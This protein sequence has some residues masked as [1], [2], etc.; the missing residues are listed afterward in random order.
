MTDKFIRKY[1]RFA[2]LVGSD[3]NPCLSRGIGSVIVDPIRNKIVS[4]GYNGPAR[5]IP[6]M[7]SY[8]ALKEFIYPQ[9]TDQDASYITCLNGSK[10]LLLGDA[11]NFA[12]MFEGC[13]KCPRKLVGAK[14]GERLD[15]CAC[16]SHESRV[17]LNN[18]K[19]IQIGNLVKSKYNGKVKSLNLETNQIEDKS[20]IGWYE[21][22]KSSDKLYK[23]ITSLSKASRFGFL[24]GKFTPD[25]ELLTIDGWKRVD[26]ITTEDYLIM[27]EQALTNNQLQ[28][29]LGSLLGG[30]SVS[31]TSGS[32][33]FIVSHS[34][35][36]REYLEFKKI[37]L[38]NHSS[39]I[40]VSKRT[41]ITP[42]GRIYKDH[43]MIKLTSKSLFELSK[44]RKMSYT[45]N[46][47]KRINKEWLN[48]I[49]WLGLCFWFLDDGSKL[50][51]STG[52]IWCHKYFKFDGDIEIIQQWLLDKFGLIS[53]IDRKQKRI[54][55]NTENF[56]ILCNN[57]Y[58]YVPKTMRYKLDV[59]YDD[60]EYPVNLPLDSNRIF[61]DKVVDIQGFSYD[62]SKCRTKVYCID[63]ADNHNFVTLNAIAHN[64]V[65]SEANALLNADCNCQGFYLFAY[66][67]VPCI[68]CCK[69]IIN[70]GIGRVY[71]LAEDSGPKDNKYE[72]WRS[73]W[74]FAKAQVA[75][76]RL[77]KEWIH[78]S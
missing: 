34:I 58:Q 9:L 54:T 26:K 33:R 18:G 67:G 3:Q 50:T 49:D 55:F 17:Q 36:Q 24:S 52:C 21:L 11:D 76:I 77:E 63:V 45:E 40:E 15:L 7:D 12:S 42:N 2:Q 73:L 19:W 65:H 39:N 71:C 16:L 29:V 22:D 69:E 57:I 5:G 32:A 25:H 43:E 6:H 51:D 35:K 72:S 70:K 27:P 48:Q 64:C 4:T 53:N 1:M 28:L 37:I 74:K 47:Y 44:I 60:L 38:N 14:S 61:T 46:G 59:E 75:V 8:D 30:A 10:E 68:N 66:C 56:K 78:A 31:Y 41:K 23:V 20:I 13:K 62:K